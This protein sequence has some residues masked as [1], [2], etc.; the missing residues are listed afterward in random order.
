MTLGR[1][2]PLQTAER[3][4]AIA[5]RSGGSAQSGC[6]AGTGARRPVNVM[7]AHDVPAGSR[8]HTSP[9]PPGLRD[10]GMQRY[11]HWT[12]G[13]PLPPLS[14]ADAAKRPV[15]SPGSDGDA[16]AEW[17]AHVDAGQIEVR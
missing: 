11:P 3:S 8:G 14:A 6:E 13:P 15:Q 4:Q 5:Q 17:M 1:T 12:A 10:N 9:A 16:F 2:R 7:A